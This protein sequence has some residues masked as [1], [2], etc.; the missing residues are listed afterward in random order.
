M[1]KSL[2]TILLLNFVLLQSCTK[3]TP[4]PA[5]VTPTLTISEIPD[6]DVTFTSL[7]LNG[8]VNPEKETV[9]ERGVCYS[10]NPDPKVTDNK[11]TALT[12]TFKIEVKDLAV[13]TKYYFRVYVTT[14]TETIYSKEQTKN[15]RSLAGTTWNVAFVHYNANSTVNWNADV[16]FNANGTT[17]YDEP[18]NPGMYLMLGTYMVTGNSIDYKMGPPNDPG[19]NLI[20]KVNGKAMSGTYGGSPTKP[21]TWSATPKQ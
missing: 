3:E 7:S 1:K 18:A 4:I 17:K 15:T 21:N 16:T 19:Y 20:G 9:V 13:N 10:T 8:N 6:S 14:S 11:L 5:K 2:L 12:N